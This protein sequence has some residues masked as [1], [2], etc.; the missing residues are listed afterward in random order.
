[1]KT[2]HKKSGT[3]L[4]ATKPVPPTTPDPHEP[5]LAAIEADDLTNITGGFRI[6]IPPRTIRVPPK[7]E[8]Q[9]A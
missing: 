2:N 3:K 8:C 6:G 1:M 9:Y 7:D 4:R 5:D